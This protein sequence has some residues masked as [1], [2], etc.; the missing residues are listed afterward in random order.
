VV[1]GDALMHPAEL[2]AAGGAI[3]LYAQNRTPG[4]EWLRRLSQHF[5]RSAWLNPEPD[6]YWAGT[7]IEPIAT[8][9]PMWML[10]L[11]GLANA[12]RYLVRGGERPQPPPATGWR[13]L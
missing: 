2:M 13:M 11:D 3:Y 6:S 4:F 1:V 7:T 5:R 10:T 12:V 9:F 8:L